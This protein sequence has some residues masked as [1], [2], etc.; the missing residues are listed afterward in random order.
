MQATLKPPKPHVVIELFVPSW[1]KS[2]HC[3]GHNKK[4]KIEVLT[5]IQKLKNLYFFVIL[6]STP[7]ADD[8]GYVPD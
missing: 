4:N 7:R 3:G 1:E 8:S 5:L 6:G 2:N